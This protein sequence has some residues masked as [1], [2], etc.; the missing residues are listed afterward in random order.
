MVI[1]TP[2]A[3]LVAIGPTVLERPVQHIPNPIWPACA[4]RAPSL[5]HE[6]SESSADKEV[7]YVDGI[8]VGARPVLDIVVHS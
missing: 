4:C 6:N 1:T 7:E 5:P 8:A 3:N 2:G